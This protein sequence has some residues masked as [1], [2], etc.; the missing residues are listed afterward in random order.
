VHL[1]W[2][3]VWQEGLDASYVEL[4][5]SLGGSG[6]EG[7]RLALQDG[8]HL[9]AIDAPDTLLL[10]QA[11]DFGFGEFGCTRRRWGSFENIRLLPLSL[12]YGYQVS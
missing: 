11:S 7:E 1:E 2:I 10:E 6:R 12:R 3:K 4:V 8:P 9:A 5:N